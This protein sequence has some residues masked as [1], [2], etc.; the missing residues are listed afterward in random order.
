MSWN[1]VADAIQA[2]VARAS[3]LDAG[4]VVWKDQDRGQP[5]TDYVALRLG[6]G[7]TLGVDYIQTST[8][9]TRAPGQEVELKVRGRREVP[10]EVECFTS[11]SVS[12]RA[13]SALELCSR[14]MAGLTLPSVRAILAAQD[15]SPFDPGT[16]NWIP[17][18]PSTRFRGRAVATVRCYMPPPT[19][20]EYAGFIERVSGTVTIQGGANG[21]QTQ[22]FDSDQ[23]DE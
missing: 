2:A 21:D 17:D 4:Q 6:G 8:D 23:A 14:I 15:V 5:L 10:L 16:P 22:T 11:E 19:V 12:G 9:L 3:G 7:I 20:V 13:G 18:V 1:D